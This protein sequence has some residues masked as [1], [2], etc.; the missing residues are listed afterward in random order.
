QGEAIARCQE[1][2]Q[3]VLADQPNAD[4]EI[5]ELGNSQAMRETLRGLAFALGLGVLVVYG[6]LAVQ[7]ASF[8]H[9]FTV[10]LALPFAATGA[11]VTLWLTGDTLNMMSLIG[12]ILL[13]GLV[14]KNSIILVDYAN[15]RL[16]PSPPGF[17]GGEGRVRGDLAP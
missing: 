1:I 8:V 13:T 3:K 9:P 16:V 4:F 17:A 11:L 12:L 5:V 14:M 2:A 15:Q 7:F 6:I 10:L